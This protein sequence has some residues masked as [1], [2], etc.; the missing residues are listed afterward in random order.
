MTPDRSH[1]D[2]VGRVAN[3]VRVEKDEAPFNPYFYGPKYPSPD[4]LPAPE[5]FFPFFSFVQQL[6]AS[7]H[8]WSINLRLRELVWP[9]HKL[10]IND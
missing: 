2:T 8:L 7:Q 1:S 9:E 10:F 3:K 6:F 4:A 5:I